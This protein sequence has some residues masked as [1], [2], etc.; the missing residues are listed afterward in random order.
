MLNESLKP[1]TLCTAVRSVLRAKR[2]KSDRFGESFLS[3]EAS[4]AGESGSVVSLSASSLS[5]STSSDPDANRAS[6]S[7]SCLACEL[8]R[9]KPPMP[10]RNAGLGAG[11]KSPRA[12]ARASLRFLL[13]HFAARRIIACSS[14][15]NTTSGNSVTPMGSSALHWS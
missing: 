4:E 13:R 6:S 2:V 11:L 10:G 5:P 3:F 9:I 1:R 14:S 8:L 15:S 12:R 7:I